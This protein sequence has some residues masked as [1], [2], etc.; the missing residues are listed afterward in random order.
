MS[1]ISGNQ[2]SGTMVGAFI[3]GALSALIVTACVAPALIAALT[4]MAQTG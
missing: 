2:K 3:M 4:V 1:G